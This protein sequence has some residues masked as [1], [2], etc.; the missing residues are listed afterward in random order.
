MELLICERQVIGER[1]EEEERG[2][3]QKTKNSHAE[4]PLIF[5]DLQ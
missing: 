2:E 3:D 4:K 1:P 5:S